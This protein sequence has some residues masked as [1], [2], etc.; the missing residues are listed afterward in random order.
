MRSTTEHSRLTNELIIARVIT[1]LWQ[2]ADMEREG[3]LT[4]PEAATDAMQAYVDAG[5]TTFDMAD[6][7]GSSE[8]L[9]GH[10]RTHSNDG[11][12]TQM[13]T[14]WVPQPGPITERLV[15]DAVERAL[16]RLQTDRLDLMQFHTWEYANPVWLDALFWLQ[17]MREE[18]LIGALGATNFDTAHL[19]IALQS[20][21]DIVSNQVCFSLLDQRPARHDG[22]VP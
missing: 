16:T 8:L 10:F 9:A 21:I 11:P 5:L 2:I 19:R 15:R 22:P 14:K 7:Y 6:H 17:K 13:F 4:D 1:G 12:N 20:G 18:G 3:R